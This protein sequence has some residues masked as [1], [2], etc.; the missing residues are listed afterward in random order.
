MSELRGIDT[1]NFGYAFQFE[2]IFESVK[3]SNS[4][5]IVECKFHLLKIFSLQL[6]DAQTLPKSTRLILRGAFLNTLAFS[7]LQSTIALCRS[8][9][10]LQS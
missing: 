4:V 10:R 9:L 1:S 6:V 8:R 3:E 7:N 2:E 5:G